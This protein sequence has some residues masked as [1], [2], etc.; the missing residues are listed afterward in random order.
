MAITS[1]RIVGTID[2]N[3]PHCKTQTYETKCD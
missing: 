1:P 3:D 2:I